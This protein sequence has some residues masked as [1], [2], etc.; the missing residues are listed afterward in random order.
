MLLRDKPMKILHSNR[1][2]NEHQESSGCQTHATHVSLSHLYYICD[3]VGG[4]RR[5]EE[6]NQS[7]LGVAIVEVC[8]LNFIKARSSLG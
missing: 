8:F 7:G 2:Q 3:V 1:L 6:C 4:I 5:G